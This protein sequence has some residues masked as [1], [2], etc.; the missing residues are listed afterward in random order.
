M[1]ISGA[2]RPAPTKPSEPNVAE[3][4]AI[5]SPEPGD[6][7]RVEVGKRVE[8]Q[9]FTSI[10]EVRER[11][12][13]LDFHPL[14]PYVA[15][16]GN[17]ISA[18]RIEIPEGEVTV[19]LSLPDHYADT[20]EVLMGTHNGPGAPMLVILPGIHSS[21]KSSNTNVFRKMALERGMNYVVLPNSLSEAMLEDMPKNH[22][23]NPRLDAEAT[24]L[25]LSRLKQSQPEYFRTISVGGYSYGALHGANLVR[26]DEEQEQ[27]LINGTLVAVSPPENLDHSMRQLDS[28]RGL[29]AEGAG[30]ISQTG[31]KYRHEVK[32]HGYEGFM[33][34]DL[35][36]RGPG[37]N[38]TEIKISDKYGSRDGLMKLVET[39]DT[40]FSHNR[41]PRNT[42]EYQDANWWQ[43]HKLREKH[44]RQ[45]ENMTYDEFSAGWMS[46]DRWLVERGLTPA[47]LAARY[48]FSEAIKAIDE[49][50]VL[51]LASAD[52][53]ILAPQDVE[54]LRRL[55]STSGELEVVRVL[56][57]GGHVGLTWN[58]EI[59]KTVA[60]F[61]LGLPA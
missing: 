37:T 5:V 50:P 52:D 38:V 19:E 28:L 43:R 33:E 8:E 54:A 60:D 39:I 42:Q 47:A 18:E 15:T 2:H 14:D 58:P 41:L 24:H 25:I 31:I 56:D 11:V 3:W 57:T 13:A 45:V 35:A 48:S 23:G 1:R 12:K 6:R 22:P 53:Y 26:Y 4:R 46:K 59:Q 7:D 32:K 20:V 27:R 36:S 29:Y 51:T 34:S 55:E 49:T 9:S 44:D 21:G 61:A 40:Q 10:A 16:V 30:S 17:A